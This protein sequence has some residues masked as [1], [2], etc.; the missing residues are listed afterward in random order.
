RP[1]HLLHASFL[2]GR[3]MSPLNRRN[4]IA[5]LSGTAAVALLNQ[6]VRAAAP[7]EGRDYARIDPPQPIADPTH[8]VVTEFFSYMCPHCALFPPT[9]AAWTKQQPADVKIERAA[10]SLGHA[11][12]VPAARTY[13]ALVSM[14]AVGKVEDAL[15]AA[16]HQQGAQLYTDAAFSD[17]MGKHG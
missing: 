16:I 9:S 1:G 2:R 11:P 12:W 5:S 7:A 17:W 3:S 6:P 15:W 10:I 13:P 8:V 4:F 14:N